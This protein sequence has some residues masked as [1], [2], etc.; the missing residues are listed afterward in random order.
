M[1]NYKNTEYLCL[2]KSK[3]IETVSEIVLKNSD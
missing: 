1:S 2:F 3:V